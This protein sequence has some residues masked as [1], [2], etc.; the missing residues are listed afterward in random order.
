MGIDTDIFIGHSLSI[1]QLLRLPH[2][3]EAEYARP[4]SPLRALFG[5]VKPD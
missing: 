3:L 5:Q 2:V 4:D 1:S